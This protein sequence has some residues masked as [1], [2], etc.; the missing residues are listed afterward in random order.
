M[1]S[2]AKA[3]R[4][5]VSDMSVADR[6]EIASLFERV[7]HQSMSTSLWDW[8]YAAG[9]GSAVVARYNG[10]IVA[11][12]GGIKRTLLNKGQEQESVQCV[13]TMVD[14][15]ERGSLS[16]HGPYFLVAQAF[17][18][19][20]VG[21]GREY[22]FGFGFPNSRVMRLGEKVG[23][24]AQVDEIVEP[25][26]DSN[27]VSP[28]SG[29]VLDLSVDADV[30]EVDSQWSKMSA[31]FGESIIGFRDSS[32]LRY[33][34]AM[35]PSYE[36]ELL[37]ISSVDKSDNPGVLVL[38]Q[39]GARIL[40]LDIVGECKYF[41]ALIQHARSMLKSRGCTELYTWVT[42][43]HFSLLD[44]EVKRVDR[45]DVRIPTSVCTNGPE[46]EELRG[47]WWLT[48]GDAEFK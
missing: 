21:Y 42:E 28:F 27:A 6:E 36:Y 31:C 30:L 48:A 11:H 7:F 25:V 37:L 40:M 18:D 12:Y 10:K 1:K 5:V 35:N 22:E 46:P 20:Y 33:R 14:P 29:A 15:T 24:Q 16:R 34:Y 47:R 26:W 38:R 23:I 2:T 9:R 45:P 44:H 13:D 41:P 8:K 3:S 32:Y 17:L 39:E 19:R 43:S 4:W